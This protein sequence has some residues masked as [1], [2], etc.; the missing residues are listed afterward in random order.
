MCAGVILCV[1]ELFA[2]VSAPVGFDAPRRR[3]YVAALNGDLEALDVLE[4]SGAVLVQGEG[5]G[6]CSRYKQ[7]MRIIHR[8][9]SACNQ[10]VRLH[11]K[12]MQLHIN[13]CVLVWHMCFAVEVAER[14]SGSCGL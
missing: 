5:T 4:P 8:T 1:H 10:D 2:G 3:A 14:A 6:C 9:V 11:A 7:D 12:A 13:V